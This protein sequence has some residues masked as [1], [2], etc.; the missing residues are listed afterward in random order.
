MVRKQT[1]GCR[2]CVNLT[3]AKSIDWFEL[4]AVEAWYYEQLN[5]EYEP[6]PEFKPSCQPVCVNQHQIHINYPNPD[7][8][9]LIAENVG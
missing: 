3:D 7:T 1:L 9:I 6:V 8:V 5:P 4:P 2:G